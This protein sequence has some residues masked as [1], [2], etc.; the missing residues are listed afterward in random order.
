M[1]ISLVWS[2]FC[3]RAIIDRDTG[4]CSIIDIIPYLKIEGP[5]SSLFLQNNTVSYIGL[6][7]ITLISLFSRTDD[8]ENDFTSNSEVELLIPRN[9][10][11]KFNYSILFQA[12]N[13]FTYSI[14]NLNDLVYTLLPSDVFPIEESISMDYKFKNIDIKNLAKS[15]ILI[16]IVDKIEKQND[17]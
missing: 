2:I 10:I 17:V 1:P 15:E 4:Q 12:H 8:L 6:G 14:I 9:P 5:F 3:R 13:A 16:K 7:D 11:Q